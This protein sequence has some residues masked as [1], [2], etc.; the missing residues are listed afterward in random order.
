ME[1]QTKKWLSIFQDWENSRMSQAQYCQVKG[2]SKST[3]GY[4]RKK[5][6]GSVTSEPEL[7]RIPLVIEK[8]Q[9]EFELS[10]PGGLKLKIPCDYEKESLLPLIHDL[11]EIL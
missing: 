9:S 3:F 7:I 10:F 1:K 5:L 6:K 11:R 8:S 2:I 4:W